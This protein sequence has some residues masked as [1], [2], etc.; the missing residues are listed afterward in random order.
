MF[1]RVLRDPLISHKQK[2]KRRKATE[3]RLTLSLPPVINQR[4]FSSKKPSSGR[5]L[6]MWNCH[7][8]LSRIGLNFNFCRAA[9]SAEWRIIGLPGMF[10]ESGRVTE[11]FAASH[12]SRNRV[13]AGWLASRWI[14]TLFLACHI[15]VYIYIYIYIYTNVR[16]PSRERENRRGRDAR[17]KLRD[18]TKRKIISKIAWRVF[19]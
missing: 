11:C 15:Y 3:T 2:Q 5:R 13:S 7:L 9:V 12:Y 17:V 1:Q 8:D 6:A 16:A 4:C 18:R 19:N 14:F 10:D